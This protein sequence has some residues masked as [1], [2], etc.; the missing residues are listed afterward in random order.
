M[1]AAPAP[2]IL[3]SHH[4]APSLEDIKKF[5]S[6][7][8]VDEPEARDFYYVYERRHW[9]KATGDYYRSWRVLASRWIFSV[10]RARA[11][12]FRQVA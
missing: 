1:K 2:V 7:K 5:F 4:E 6:G 11:T 9:R 8:G 12:P 10:L 3:F